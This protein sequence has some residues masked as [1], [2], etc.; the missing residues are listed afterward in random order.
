MRDMKPAL[1]KYF[2][3][4]NNMKKHKDKTKER[5]ALAKN[6]ELN[7]KRRALAAPGED[8]A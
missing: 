1:K 4:R 5:L 8:E 3:L 2:E 7:N 6:L